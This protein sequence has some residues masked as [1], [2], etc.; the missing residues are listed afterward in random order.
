MSVWRRRRA[1]NQAYYSLVRIKFRMLQCLLPK[2]CNC[3]IC[4]AM[5]SEYMRV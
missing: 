2:L 1:H 3:T 4:K 5:L